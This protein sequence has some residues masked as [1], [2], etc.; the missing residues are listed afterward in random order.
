MSGRL[1]ALWRARTPRERWLIAL[2]L[3]LLALVA[4]WLLVLRPLGDIKAAARQ[5]HE[6]AVAALA[7]ARA[8]AAAIGALERRR[9][10]PIAGPLDIAVARAA[11]EAGFQL[12]RLQAEGAGRVALT[13]DAARP[14]ALFGWLGAM[15]RR[16]LIVERLS[17]TG[18]GDRTLAAQVL[19]R[20]RTG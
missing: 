13:I 6:A 8:D 14:Q 12:S 19:L 16:G 17:A 9:P 2:M 4:V 11:A 10:A 20:A 5:R 18:N 1:R 15:E 3:A 7:D